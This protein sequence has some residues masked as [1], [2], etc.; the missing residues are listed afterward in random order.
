MTPLLAPDPALPQRDVLLD[1]A[2]MAPVLE[3]RLAEGSAITRCEVARVKYRVGESLRVRYALETCDR[4]YDVASRTFARGRAESAFRRALE[5]AVAVG[6][7]RPVGWAP[8]LETVFWT[9]PNDRK[10]RTDA[11]DELP[12]LLGERVR[13]VR[14]VA[15]APEKSATIRADGE[16]G[17]LAYAK[18]YAGA[19]AARALALHRRLGAAGIRV[20]R[21]IAASASGRLIALEPLPGRA[22]AE[23]EGTE[24]VHAHHL[25][26]KTIAAL[27]EQPPTGGARFHR[28]DPNRVRAAADL[29]ARVRPDAAEPAR[30]VAAA[31]AWEPPEPDVL[32]HG[33]LHPKNAI[34]DGGGI[35]VL[36]L[37]QSAGGPAS[38]DVG[39]LLA[40]LRYARVVGDL[41]PAAARG[42]AE[43]FLAGYASVRPLPAR[44]ALRRATAA[45]LLAERVVRAINRVRPAGLAALHPLLADALEVLDG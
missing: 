27:H 29:V 15:Y 23:L 38:A 5:G 17:A 24:L 3:R 10:L 22:L 13:A 45:A 40:G 39:S 14:L 34:V 36:D 18:L 8:E 19:E 11:L 30:A 25:L 35:G 28:L 42:C 41:D 26:G 6:R 37:D 7:L 31:T 9:F 16:A 32:L 1:P 21:P 43:S 20:P 33:D 2:R 4:R 12:G 44:E